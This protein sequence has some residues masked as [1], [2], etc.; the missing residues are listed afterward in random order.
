MI[1]HWIEIY[2]V[3]LLAYVSICCFFFFSEGF[4][5]GWKY[6]VFPQNQIH[7][8]FRIFQ[9]NLTK[10]KKAKINFKYNILSGSN[11]I[12]MY[13]LP[14]TYY[15]Y[16]FHHWIYLIYHPNAYNLHYFQI[17][18]CHL[19]D[20]AISNYDK[21]IPIINVVIFEIAEISLFRTPMHHAHY[22]ISSHTFFSVCL[23]FHMIRW[24]FG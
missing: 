18:F 7:I 20:Y 16:R 17:Y 10:K 12:Y 13:M 15:I 21:F 8:Q 9:I 4:R 14:H 23:S 22:F 6:A 3:C 2:C 24:R 5:G 19:I 1:L 11:I